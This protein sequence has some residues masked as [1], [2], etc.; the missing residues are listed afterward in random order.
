MLYIVIVYNNNVL[1]MVDNAL[2]RYDLKEKND[3][4]LIKVDNKVINGY[5]IDEDILYILLSN[6][7]LPNNILE[8]SLQNF[9]ILKNT[10]IN[11]KNIEGFIEE[12]NLIIKRFNSSQLI[13]LVE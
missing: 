4:E 13:F 7:K 5:Y 2:K 10:D 3:Y 9:K 1:Y 11:Y 12:N 8:I 6:D